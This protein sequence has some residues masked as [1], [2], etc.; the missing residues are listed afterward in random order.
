MEVTIKGKPKEIKKLLNAI[1][2]S[3]EQLVT[4]E[5]IKSALK[6]YRPAINLSDLSNP[7]QASHVRHYKRID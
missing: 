3:E 5:E 4:R 2:G 6:D 1:S 7:L